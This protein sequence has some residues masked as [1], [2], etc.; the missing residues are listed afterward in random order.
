MEGAKPGKKR[1]SDSGEIIPVPHGM[2]NPSPILA[3][4]I[5]RIRT[6]KDAKKLLGRLISQFTK[7]TVQSDDA[8]TLAH[9]LSVFIQAHQAVDL[10]ERLEQ[11]ETAAGKVAP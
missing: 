4:T 10:E 1:P 7:G 8:K 11:L 2:G 9:L 3:G 6:A 5:P